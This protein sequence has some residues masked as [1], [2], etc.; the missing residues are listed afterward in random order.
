MGLAP[1]PPPSS[2]GKGCI[3]LHYYNLWEGMARKDA[4]RIPLTRSIPP[5]RGAQSSW[6]DL[7]GYPPPAPPPPRYRGP[8]WLPL[9]YTYHTSGRHGGAPSS[10]MP[11]YTYPHRLAPSPGLWRV[12]PPPPPPPSPISHRSSYLLTAWRGTVILNASLHVSST[13]PP[14]PPQLQRTP[15]ILLHVAYLRTAWRG[16]VILNASL[17]VSSTNNIQTSVHKPPQSKSDF[18]IYSNKHFPLWCQ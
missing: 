15:W 16:T 14:P 5:D 10:W 6:N 18:T 2:Q 1:P 13:P 12:Q 11:P 9:L 8:P 7:Y 3:M 17:H 4:P